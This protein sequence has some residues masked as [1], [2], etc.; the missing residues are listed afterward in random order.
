MEACRPPEPG[1]CRWR[2]T[3]AKGGVEEG[4]GGSVGGLFRNYRAVSEELVLELPVCEVLSPFASYLVSYVRYGAMKEMLARADVN[5]RLVQLGVIHPT[6]QEV[7]D[8]ALLHRLMD[9]LDPAVHQV[10]RRAECFRHA[11]QSRVVGMETVT[12]KKHHSR[13]REVSHTSGNHTQRRTGGR[14]RAAVLHLGIILRTNHQG[15]R[16]CRRIL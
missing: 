3:H 11:E 1:W 14:P 15:L 7:D 2:S 5:E 4:H 9:L 16:R 10:E 8:S 6:V 12:Y 13:L